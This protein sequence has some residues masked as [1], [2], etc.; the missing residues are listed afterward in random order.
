MV[1]SA[2]CWSIMCLDCSGQDLR[3]ISEWEVDVPLSSDFAISHRE[4]QRARFKV[5]SGNE[6][7]IT[8]YYSSFTRVLTVRRL[9]YRFQKRDI[10]RGITMPFQFL[11]EYL[12]WTVYKAQRMHINTN[13][14]L[15]VCLLQG[16][17]YGYA[18]MIDAFYV[19]YAVKLS[20]S[21][22]SPRVT[23]RK[24]SSVSVPTAPERHQAWAERKSYSAKQ[25]VRAVTERVEEV[26]TGEVFDLLSTPAGKT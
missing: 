25:A 5:G 23:E 13:R 26:D 2:L 10:V 7:T 16:P 3:K 9:V 22:R 6:L 19:E 14:E 20:D 17:P 21:I 12:E 24:R 1:F 8:C 18:T 4:P 11:R 15:S